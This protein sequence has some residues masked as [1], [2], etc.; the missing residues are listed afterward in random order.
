M[1]PD[2]QIWVMVVVREEGAQTTVEAP[3]LLGVPVE[4]PQ[5]QFLDKFDAGF[6]PD[7]VV[8]KRPDVGGEVR[9]LERA[10]RLHTD[11]DPASHR[12]R[13]WRGGFASKVLL[14]RLLFP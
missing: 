11:A 8:I 12:V 9:F 10:R 5:V 2:F 14:H 1:L 7:Q 13:L 4:I 6:E 3:Q